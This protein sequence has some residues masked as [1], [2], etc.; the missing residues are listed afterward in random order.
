[1]RLPALRDIPAV[2]IAGFLGIAVYQV[3]LNYGEVKVTAGAA[4]L[5]VNSEPMLTA[6][7]A[8]IFLHERLKVLAWVGV[9]VSFVG[10]LLIA[11]GESGGLQLEPA[12]FL[13]LL[14]ALGSSAYFVYQKPYLRRYTALE[15]TAYAIWAGTLLMLVFAPGL[16]AAISSAPFDATLAVIYLGIFPAAI[17][18]VAWAYVLS[19][20]PASYASNFLNLIPVLAIL[21]GWAWLGEIP[22]WLSLIG[23][24]IAFSGVILVNIS[25]QRIAPEVAEGKEATG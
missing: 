21:I 19:R 8:V 2:F 17:G 24:V 9:L 20:L 6:L 1:M 12:A 15:F 16:P 22:T 14:A 23:G 4:S 11:L 25:E 7:L 3:A 13:V 10:I 5:L 18:Y